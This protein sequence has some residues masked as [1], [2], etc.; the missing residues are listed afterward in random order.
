MSVFAASDAEGKN[1]SVYDGNELDSYKY[2]KFERTEILSV[3]VSPVS[4]DAEKGKTLQFTAEVQGVGGYSASVVWKVSGANSANT[5]IDE[6]GLLSVA[7]DETAESI[8]VTAV[9]SDDP[10]KSASVTVSVL[11]ASGDDTPENG[12][13]LPGWAIALIAAGACLVAAAVAVSVYF[14]VKKFE[15]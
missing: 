7:A 1:E 12:G 2:L 5:R 15:K 14:I 13:G 8:V 4:A 3:T 11:A 6:N 9:S 10:E